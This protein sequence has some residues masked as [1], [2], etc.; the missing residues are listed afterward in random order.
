MTARA[1]TSPTRFV[2]S[3]DGTRIAYQVDGTGPPLVTVDGGLAHRR[4]GLGPGLRQ[5]LKDRFTVYSYD[6][7]GRGESGRGATPHPVDAEVEDLVA[8]LGATGGPAHVFGHSAGAALALEAARRG[9]P[10]L[11]MV[12]HEVPFILDTSQ[13]AD[14]PDFSRHLQELVDQGRNGEAL[15]AFFR[16]MEVPAP[17]RLVVRVL[18]LWRKLTAVAPTL[19]YDVALVAPFRKQAPL[20]V[21][22]YDAVTAETLLV[23]GDKS[24][25]Y[26]RNAQPLIAAALPHGRVVTVPGQTHDVKAKAIAPLIAAHLLATP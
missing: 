24:Y 9:A 21:G 17:A 10:V 11:R 20:P 1:S 26:M 22:Y 5:A 3:P 4:Q 23:S 18:P 2:T 8:V 6:R 14:D 7:R 19:P 13:P 16:L 15:T 25:P 12:C